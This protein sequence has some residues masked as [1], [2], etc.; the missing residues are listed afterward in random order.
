MCDFTIIQDDLSL[1]HTVCLTGF[2]H[3]Q[4]SMT[5][6]STLILKTSCLKPFCCGCRRAPAAKTEWGG[7]VW[8]GR[9]KCLY[10][11]HKHQWEKLLLP[12][13]PRERWAHMAPAHM[14]GMNLE[15]EQQLFIHSNEWSPSWWDPGRIWQWEK[16]QPFVFALWNRHQGRQ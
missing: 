3:P 14:Q 11:Q 13:Q 4:V 16:P 6:F 9:D 7:N 12:A 10:K 5:S 8:T 1:E 15:S 2:C